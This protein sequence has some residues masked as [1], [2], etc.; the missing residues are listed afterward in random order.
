[1]KKDIRRDL[2]KRLKQIRRQLHLTQK[3]YFSS[4]TFFR[5]Y[6]PIATLCC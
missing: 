5:S 4:G 2:G 1:M 3:N 6:K